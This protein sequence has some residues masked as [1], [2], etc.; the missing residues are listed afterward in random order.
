MANGPLGG[1]CGPS[2][3][4]NSSCTGCGELY[5]DPWINEPADCVDPCNTCGNYNG[6]SCGSCRPLFEGFRSLW[7]YRCGDDCG[8]CGD[9]GCAVSCGGGL[10]GGNACGCGAEICG[11]SCGVESC[12]CD[13]GC[14]PSCGCEVG[15]ESGCGVDAGCG[16]SS[17]SGGET[18]GHE[19]HYGNNVE[20]GHVIE[21]GE[22]IVEGGQIPTPAHVPQSIGSA[23]PAVQQPYK[24]ERTRKIFNPRPRVATG[25]NRSVGY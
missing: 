2:V 12:G 8:D 10:L 23:K 22:Y 6:Q 15:Y 13:G 18:I 25:D 11:G 24:P 14:G 19:I 16:C 20:H 7:G 3:A 21:G 17:C 1:C 5:V 9:S 4:S